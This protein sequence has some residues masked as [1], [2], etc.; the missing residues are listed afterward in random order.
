MWFKP[1]NKHQ[2]TRARGDEVERLTEKFLKKKA[3]IN[4]SLLE[5]V[6]RDRLIRHRRKLLFLSWGQEG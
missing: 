3:R 1:E 6:K 4:A 2:H 5:V